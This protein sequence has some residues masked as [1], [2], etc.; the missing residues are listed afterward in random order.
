M[1]HRDRQRVGV[2]VGGE[3][4][5]SQRTVIER[6]QQPALAPHRVAAARELVLAVG[7]GARRAR[8]AP[9]EHARVQALAFAQRSG[10][11]PCGECSPHA[12]EPA[13]V[14]VREQHPAVVFVSHLRP[15]PVRQPD[16]ARELE[17]SGQPLLHRG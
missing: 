3:R 5:E 11:E 15:A 10:A 2:P 14:V 13:P 9:E 17:R 8:R 7:R 4:A 1:E 16:R 6:D 12:I